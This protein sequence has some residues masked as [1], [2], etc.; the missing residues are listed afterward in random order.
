MTIK[1]DILG[2][3]SQR[4]RELG[5]PVLALSE[6]ADTSVST[7]KRVLSGDT[8]VSYDTLRR[9]GRALGADFAI[10]V[11]APDVMIKEEA[12]RKASIVAR[13]VQG[14]SALEAQAVDKET[15]NRIAQTAAAML[16]SSL[17]SKLWAK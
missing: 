3:L 17:G 9:I 7:V 5:M 8:S 13:A 12:E 15:M 10:N 6:R 1:Q 11:R 16:V 4:R 2:F 14:T